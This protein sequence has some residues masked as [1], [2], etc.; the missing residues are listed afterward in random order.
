MLNCFMIT[1]QYF[2]NCVIP[3]DACIN[4]YLPTLTRYASH[5]CGLMTSISR[6]KDNF[7]LLTQKSGQNIS[8]HVINNEN[9][10]QFFRIIF[11]K[12]EKGAEWWFCI[13]TKSKQTG[14]VTKC[15]KVVGTSSDIFGKVRKFSKNRRKSSE[16]AGSRSWQDENLTHL[17]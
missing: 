4:V 3:Y 16:V 15:S 2:V 17:T 13:L 5:A 7:S 10:I 12:A 14:I 8:S 6:I 9:S 1:Y 11:Q